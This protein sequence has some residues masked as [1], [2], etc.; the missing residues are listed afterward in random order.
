MAEKH[1]GWIAKDKYGDFWY[2]SFRLNKS[3]TKL[4][5]EGKWNKQYEF[6]VVKVKLMEVK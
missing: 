1:D 5:I 4:S 6:K 3:D 2:G